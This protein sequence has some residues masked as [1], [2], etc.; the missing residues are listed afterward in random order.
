MCVTSCVVKC[1]EQGQQPEMRKNMTPGVTEQ[2]NYAG[3]SI[4]GAGVGYAEKAG[5][6]PCLIEWSNAADT[7]IGGAS[8]HDVEKAGSVHY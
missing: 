6:T 8:R 4:G 1:K 5:W 2:S 3:T 7:C